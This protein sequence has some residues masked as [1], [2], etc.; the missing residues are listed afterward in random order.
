IVAF[1]AT[2]WAQ[3][4]DPRDVAL[5]TAQPFVNARLASLPA[6]ST[7]EPGDVFVDDLGQAHVR[8]QHLYQGIPV[9]ESELIAHVDLKGPSFIGL[10]D[11]LLSFGAIPTRPNINAGDAKGRALGHEGLPP[12]LASKDD[13]TV[14]VDENMGVLSWRIHASDD[15]D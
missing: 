11:A 1:S 10:T 2:L 8:Y 4:Q 15:N 3:L 9:F 12:G 5:R 7:L 13:L 6:G 14:L